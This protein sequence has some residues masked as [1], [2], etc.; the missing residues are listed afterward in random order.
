MIARVPS[1]ALWPGQADSHVWHGFLPRVPQC[2]RRI[3]RLAMPFRRAT[4]RS[5]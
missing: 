4:R 2:G 5:C 1:K 3:K